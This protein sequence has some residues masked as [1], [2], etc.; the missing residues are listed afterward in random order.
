VD[1][2]HLAGLEIFAQ[3]IC[4]DT[5]VLPTNITLTNAWRATVLP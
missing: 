1:D 5:S 4:Q 2:S 3:M